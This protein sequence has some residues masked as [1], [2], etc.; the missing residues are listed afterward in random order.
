MSLNLT[1]FAA[2]LLGLAAVSGCALYSDVSIGPL[3]AAP[4]KLDRG[5][6]VQSMVKKAD[7]L[8]ALEMAPAVEARAQRNPADLVSL[9]YAELAAGRYD[10]ARQHLRAAIDLQPFRTTYAQAAWHLAQLEYMNNSYVTS[11]EWA[12]TAI[13]HGMGIL[14]WHIQY[15]EAL[16]GIQL[17]RFRGLPSDEVALKIGRPDVPR[18]EVRINKANEPVVGVID[19]GAVLSIMSERMAASIGVRRLPVSGGTFYG[20]LNEPIAVKFGLLDSLEIGAVVVENVPVAIMPDEKMRFIVSGKRDFHIDLLLGA[21]L[22]KE[23]RLELAYSRNR[24]VFTR[25]TARDRRP[26]PDQNIFFE[27]FRPNVRGTVNKH[28]WYLFVLDTGSE[29]T[30]LNETQLGALPINIFAP[31]IH[32]ATLQGLG[33]AKKRGSKVEKVEVGVDRWAGSFRTIPMYAAEEHER[34][35]GIIGQNFLK[36]FDVVLDFGRMRLDLKRR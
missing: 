8:R 12:R 4:G 18:V 17:Y 25:L 24:A 23:F 32:G 6:D 33:G 11:L 10:V 34:S 3:V 28:G 1:R 13:D 22:L 2:A 19:S 35:V 5:S 9:G 26:A 16:S 30:Y 31:R 15:L 36:N 7:Y 21:N 14:P 20:L 27:N 29:V